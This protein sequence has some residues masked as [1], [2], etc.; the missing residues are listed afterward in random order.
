MTW[1]QLF[2]VKWLE[3][4]A[5][6]CL[7]LL[8]AQFVVRRLHQP[9]DRIN[10]IVLTFLIALLVPPL[11]SL[12]AA[13]T[14]SLALV[15][16]S[17]SNM[18]APPLTV[19]Q[20]PAN[21]QQSIP[22]M[23]GIA[24]LPESSSASLPNN[25]AVVSNVASTAS[26][27][28]PPRRIDLWNV[29][30]V[31]L[32]V[33]HGV[34]IALL[35]IEWGFGAYCLRGIS[36]RA[37]PAGQQLR[38]VWNEVSIEQGRS[39]RLLVSPEVS[40]PLTY[41][42]WKSTVVIPKSVAEGDPAA[43]RFCLAHEWS[44]LD[45][46]DLFTWRL[47]WF[48]Q[49]GLCFQPL[50]WTLRRELYV[51]Q[52]FLADHRAAGA[53][54]DA[55]EYSALLLDFARQRMSRPIAGAMAFLDRSSQLSRRIHMLLSSH[56]ILRQRS[57]RA[58][59]LM[60]G[61][62]SLSCGIAISLVRLG[63]AEASDGAQPVAVTKPEEPKPEDP[64]PKE[65]PAEPKPNASEA[66]RYTGVILDKATGK[67]IPDATVV[68]RRS[69]LTSQQNDL[70]A[71]TRHQTDAD[72]KYTFEIPPEQV[73]VTS[74][75]IQLDVLQENYASK[76]GFGYAL[77]MIRKNEG[78]GERPFFEKVELDRSDPIIGTVV[79]PDGTPLSGVKIQGYSR[80]SGT[81]FRDYGSFTDTT[82]DAAG[83]FRLNMVKGGTGVLWVLPKDYASTSRA[84]TDTRGDFGEFRLR[85]GVRVS[86]RV[87]NAEGQPVPHVPVNIQYQGGGNETVN[88]LPVSTSIR[89]SALTDDSGQ[90]EFDP[91]PTG[92]Y[93]V[94][95]EEHRSDPITRDPE[96]YEIPGV[97][98]PRKVKIK[99]GVAAPPLEIQASP[100]VIFNAQIFDSKGA[101]TR[102]H[103]VMMFGRLDG[104]HWFG[105]GR[106]DANG[107][108][109][110]RVPHGLQQVQLDLITNEHGA[111]RFRRGKGKELESERRRVDLGTMND[112][113][114]G[115]EII[116]YRAPIVL[117]NAVDADQQQV[118]GFQVTAT[119][120]W[121]KQQY[122]LQG[123]Q[124]SDLS[125]EHQDDGRYRTTQML[126]DEDVKFTIKAPGYEAVT[127]TI[128]L[129]EGATKDLVV[130]LNKSDSPA[131]E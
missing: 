55:L 65:Q 41:G 86:G 108:I 40:T 111:L 31:I 126:P 46:S 92:D 21:P 91:L 84:V 107:T 112:D 42:G 125:F 58:F 114:E 96:R 64:K 94:I 123:E 47:A 33:G 120:S 121:G 74:L 124:R 131:A 100:H 9:A 18:A 106:P 23:T 68:V 101:K 98:L 11:I 32:L 80:S 75:Y 113:V 43:L 10:L 20:S 105:R 81:N 93:R 35:M 85:P 116:R 51:C 89:R 49:F 115:F 128:R 66:L 130:T 8:I 103:E 102:G 45:S 54:R 77:S 109:A 59:C 13:P 118:K 73:A 6:G 72:G 69:K 15:G 29:V 30:A 71:E 19:T 12:T 70:I 26:S 27:S 90:F 79:S 122:V 39:V 97:F 60:A 28:S 99:E 127:K 62:I 110:L 117:I 57:P 129:E 78:L 25:P 50:F 22:E 4:S 87:I 67:G 63:A 119:Y 16:Q 2:V 88:N 37:V 17:R 53:G 3:F 82:T 36:A 76:T 5:A 7:L 52:D 1:S 48:C 14:W 104:E 34:A 56:L 95:P 38:D 44:H 24:E 83:K 61:L